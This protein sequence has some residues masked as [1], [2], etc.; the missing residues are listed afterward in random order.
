M[1]QKCKLRGEYSGE[2]ILVFYSFLGHL[3]SSV[4]AVLSSQLLIQC[5]FCCLPVFLCWNSKT[6]RRLRAMKRRRRQH[7][8]AVGV[9]MVVAGGFLKSRVDP[10][11]RSVSGRKL[12]HS[13][14]QISSWSPIMDNKEILGYILGLL[15]F[16][17]SWT[18]RFP[19]LCRARRGQMY[20]FSGLLCSVSGALYTAAILLY[21]VRVEFLIRVMPWLLSSIG[22]VILDLLISIIHWWKTGTRQM[23]VKLSADTERLLDMQRKPSSAQTNVL[24]SSHLLL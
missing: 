14:M 10:A 1:C 7:L 3:C 8:L 12:L 24:Q 13:S 22:C 19:V 23:T 18:S 15:A 21:D 6:Q 4:G 16:V 20:I 9:L 2:T 11:L 5:I 17:I